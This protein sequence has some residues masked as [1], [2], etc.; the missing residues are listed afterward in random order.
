MPEEYV[1]TLSEKSLKKAK[2]ELNEIPKERL[3]AVEAFREWVLSQKHITCDT[4]K[5]VEYQ[6]LGL[7]L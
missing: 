6:I 7:C 2:K 5:E 1:C 4:S 3:G